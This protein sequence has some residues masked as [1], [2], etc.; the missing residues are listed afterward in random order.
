LT[1]LNSKHNYNK[2][3]KTKQLCKKTTNI[4]INWSKRK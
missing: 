3:H 2:K 1:K 4:R